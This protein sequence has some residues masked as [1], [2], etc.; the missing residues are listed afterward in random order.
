MA[1]LVAVAGDVEDAKGSFSW[2]RARKEGQSG[3]TSGKEHR[4]SVALAVKGPAKRLDLARAEVGRS[5]C[6]ASF[7]RSIVT[8]EDDEELH[9]WLTFRVMLAGTRTRVHLGEGVESLYSSV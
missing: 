9:A 4:S 6:F 8:A 7:A 5:S 2:H 1:A 3:P